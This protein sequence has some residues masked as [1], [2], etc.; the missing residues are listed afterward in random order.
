MSASLAV[1]LEMV[2]QPVLI[3]DSYSAVVVV[4]VCL[5][6]GGFRPRRWQSGYG[7]IVTG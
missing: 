7:M 6:G 5:S 2:M 1:Q 4:A 3:V